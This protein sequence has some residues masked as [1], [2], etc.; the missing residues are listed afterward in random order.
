VF[1]SFFCRG[2]QV[3]NFV[4]PHPNRGIKPK[5]AEKLAGVIQKIFPY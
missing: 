5:T 4:W 3:F 2:V 1:F